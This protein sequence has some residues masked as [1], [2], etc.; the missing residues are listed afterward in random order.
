M[1]AGVGIP[2][3]GPGVDRDGFAL[4]DQD[5]ARF[6]RSEAGEGLMQVFFLSAHTRD[7]SRVK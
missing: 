2:R 6:D 7:K 1:G 4:R 3:L 5:M